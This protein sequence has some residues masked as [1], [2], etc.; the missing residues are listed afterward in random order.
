MKWRRGTGSLSAPTPAGTFPGSQ[1]LVGK[2]LAH[3]R[4]WLRRQELGRGHAQRQ[5]EGK[6]LKTGPL[7]GEGFGMRSWWL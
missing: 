7:D 4:E 3:A 1:G 5:G 6:Q 2:P